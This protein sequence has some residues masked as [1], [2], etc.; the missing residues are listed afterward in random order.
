LRLAQ[1]IHTDIKRDKLDIIL[2]ILEVANEPV[3]KT[4]ILY[5]AGINYYQLSRYLDLLLKAKMIEQVDEPYPAF[6]TTEKGRL[7]LRLFSETFDE[8]EIKID[9]SSRTDRPGEISSG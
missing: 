5:S 1:N 8:K 4:H 6:R 7:L 2:I 3:R 9:T